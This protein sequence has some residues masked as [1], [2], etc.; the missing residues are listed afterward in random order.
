V[1]AQGAA[2]RGILLQ[3]APGVQ[4]DGPVPL[5]QATVGQG[6]ELVDGVERDR[7][8]VGGDLVAHAAQQAVDWQATDLAKEVPEG[9]IDGADGIAI[10]GGAQVAPEILP[11][12]LAVERIPAD[13]LPFHLLDIRP[14]PIG[15]EALDALVG[16]EAQQGRLSHGTIGHNA[17][18][19]MVGATL[20]LNV[21][22][23]DCRDLHV[24]PP[25][26][27]GPRQATLG[28]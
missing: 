18:A 12:S 23:L 16:L 2:K 1:L 14:A 5:G 10:L 25:P 26:G 3:A 7:A 13:E 15:R 22:N 6:H 28:C 27:W 9:A 24:M 11:N 20:P 8:G 4:L 21:V 17:I 19:P